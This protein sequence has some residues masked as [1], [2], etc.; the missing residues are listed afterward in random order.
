MFPIDSVV[1]GVL[2]IH[3]ACCSNANVPVVLY[4]IERGADVNSRRWPRKYSGEK[5]R[6]GAQT[7]GTTGSTPLHFAAA[8]GCLAIVEVL[9]RHGAK[10]DVKDK[11]GSSP[12][13]VAAARNHPEVA[14]LLRQHSA[15]QRGVLDTT[16]DDEGKDPFVSPRSSSDFHHRLSQILS[17]STPYT[18]GATGSSSAGSVHS[19]SE[20]GSSI[21]P[22]SP[23]SSISTRGSSRTT[24]PNTSH[25]KE[26]SA[27]SLPLP[28]PSQASSSSSSSHTPKVSS[29]RRV[30]LPS[31]MESPCSPPVLPPPRQSCDLSRLPRSDE[32]LMASS[33]A[34]KQYQYISAGKTAVSPMFSNSSTPNAFSST[35]TASVVEPAPEPPSSSSSP[36]SS[37]TSCSSPPSST[38]PSKGGAGTSPSS[39]LVGQEEHA[40]H[41]ARAS[42]TGVDLSFPAS[43]APNKDLPSASTLP[44]TS[45]LNRRR[46]VDASEL[47]SPQSAIVVHRRRSVDILSRYS[48]GLK[49][50]SKSRKDNGGGSKAKTS[51]KERRSS[52][53]SSHQSQGSGST[54]SE[55]SSFLN[56][57]WTF[58]PSTNQQQLSPHQPQ[59]QRRSADFSGEINPFRK[60]SS[61]SRSSGG[62]GSRRGSN[63]GSQNHGQGS[64]HGGSDVGM[65]ASAAAPMAAPPHL[66]RSSSQP[67]LE[68]GRDPDYDALNTDYR[69]QSLDLQR[70]PLRQLPPSSPLARR[71][72]SDSHR[73]T[74]GGG[75]GGSSN[76]SRTLLS[77]QQNLQST[78]RSPKGHVVGIPRFH[79]LG[80]AAGAAAAAAMA[81]SGGDGGEMEILGSGHQGSSS[82]DLQRVAAMTT[83]STAPAP[84]RLSLGSQTRPHYATLNG[85]ATVSGRLSRFWG[86][87]MGKDHHHNGNYH[88]GSSSTTTTSSASSTNSSKEGGGG[89]GRPVA[90]TP[91]GNWNVCDFAEASGEAAAQALVKPEES[92]RSRSSMLYRLSG[93]WS[94][95]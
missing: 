50:G 79:S 5:S 82:E 10:V 69:R 16:P 33:E 58:S 21:S 87:G 22:A 47:L 34:E 92:G 81:A 53:A 6:V 55:T 51:Q 4:L 38:S 68:L 39:T 64:G 37:S 20:K 72:S 48:S 30:S 83:N 71:D 84:P 49:S 65:A 26:S 8:N 14:N 73:R 35:A 24:V 27:Q 31:I 94:R 29:Q 3:A 23:V 2:P 61:L 60:P 17:P 67:R 80:H 54:P 89:G 13:S 85:H 75:G 45:A 42:T 76:S 59:Q 43:S 28:A 18:S 77:R 40:D 57:C 15:M 52:D 91:P 74:G 93:I 78:E 41:R 32:P 25:A 56:G 11:Y 12:L 44:N 63:H 90:P 88:Y 19:G 70:P 1:N 9:L 95:R 46:S 86:Y 7:V 62:G 36:L 66:V